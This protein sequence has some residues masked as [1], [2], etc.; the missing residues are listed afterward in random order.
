[1]IRSMEDTFLQKFNSNLNNKEEYT[2]KLIG[3]R[4]QQSNVANDVIDCDGYDL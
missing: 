4:R 2:S 3:F 1:M